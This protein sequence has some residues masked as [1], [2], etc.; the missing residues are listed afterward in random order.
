MSAKSTNRGADAPEGEEEEVGSGATSPPAEERPKKRRKKRRRKKADGESK[1]EASTEE[2]TAKRKRR[3]RKSDED[4]TVAGS[5][6]DEPEREEGAEADEDEPPEWT[7]DPLPDGPS[8]ELRF[9]LLVTA[10]AVTTFYFLTA[11]RWI[12][13]GDTALVLDEMLELKVNSHVNNHTLA[14]LF[15]WLFS[16][17]PWGELAFRVNLMSVFF[18]SIA[19]TLSFALAYRVL[20][21]LP[22]ALAITAAVAVMHSMWWHSTIVE[23]YAINAAALM[24]W[25]LCLMKDEEVEHSKYYYGACVIAGLGVVN[26][27]QMG[28]LSVGVFVFAILQRDKQGY[29][30]IVRWLKM[31]GFFLVGFLPYLV[32]LVRDMAKSPD[33]IKIIYWAT[34][35]DF[36]S[37]MFDFELSKVFRPLLIEFLVQFPSPMLLFAALGIYYVGET[38]YYGKTNISVTVVFFINTLFFAQF[39]TWDKFA[40]L[41]PSFLCVAYWAMIGLRYCFEW[42]AES[43]KAWAHKLQPGLYGL[44]GVAVFFP[45]YFYAHLADWGLDEGFWHSRFNNNYTVN[46]HNCATYIANPNKA[47]WNEVDAFSRALFDK[48]PENAAFMDDDSRVYYPL[49]SYFQKHYGM[50]PDLRI[51]LMNTWGFSGW[52]MTEDQYVNFVLRNIAR[53]RMFLVSIGTPFTGTIDKLGELRIVPRRFELTP[54]RWVFELVRESSLPSELPIYVSD[55][56]TGRSFNNPV[57]VLKWHFD[58]DEVIGVQARFKKTAE[59]V[60]IKFAYARDGEGHFTSEPFT[61]DAGNTKV[62]SYLDDAG[63]RPVGNYTVTMIA[64]DIECWTAKFVVK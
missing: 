22:A 34:G 19:V 17:L 30:L 43:S 52:G 62:W 47:G 37:R 23:N 28:T 53:R 48:L 16:K 44:V 15:G 42:I 60:T 8:K 26:H 29:N 61:V 40:F 3:R 46:S 32:I 18:G 56:V 54:D 13:L 55:L 2:A 35:G 6:G 4:T 25:I 33:P 31:A 38:S 51:L 63:N 24:G 64:N 11:S 45:P 12:G 7:I 5:D 9:G 58:K 50:R 57:P 14:I 20:K 21:R 41:L 49:K 59:P 36:Q 27:V 10:V 1:T 39:H